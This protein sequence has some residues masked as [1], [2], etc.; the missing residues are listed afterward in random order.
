MN[1]AAVFPLEI[2]QQIIEE[3]SVLSPTSYSHP[4]NHLLW[5]AREETLSSCS[6]TCRAWYQYSKPL[7]FHTIYISTL[8]EIY[9]RISC[10]L[11]LLASL[12]ND[13]PAL[14]LLIRCLV[15]HIT[16]NEKLSSL[17]DVLNPNRLQGLR[18]LYVG[19]YNHLCMSAMKR[20]ILYRVV[21]LY[22]LELILCS[23]PRG[24]PFNIQLSEDEAEMQ[25]ADAWP[26]RSLVMRR[27]A[28]RGCGDVM[29]TLCPSEEKMT[30][31]DVEYLHVPT[32]DDLGTSSLVQRHAG[33]LRELYVSD[34][35][36]HP[37]ICIC[38]SST[39][40]YS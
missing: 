39:M 1:A 24:V 34:L 9:D 22:L 36:G 12:L 4:S 14:Y 20:N 23:V 3:C 11:Q 35:K 32:L 16:R 26:L 17:P 28:L 6:L 5:A 18:T 33:S 37:Y 8:P 31:K 30:S 2:F 15:I 25:D 19:G 21:N 38:K 13:D 7:L 10:K 40:L 29:L 27:N